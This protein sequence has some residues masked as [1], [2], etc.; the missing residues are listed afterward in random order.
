MKDNLAGYKILESQPFINKTLQIVLWYS[1][2]RAVQFWMVLFHLLA[3]WHYLS[4]PHQTHVAVITK[5]NKIN[6]LVMS[7]DYYIPTFCWRLRGMPTIAVVKERS[8]L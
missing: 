8:Q 5:N 4:V 1:Y 2:H 3:F 7:A 6:S